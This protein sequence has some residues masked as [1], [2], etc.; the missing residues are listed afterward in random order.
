MY[1]IHETNALSTNDIENFYGEILS[2]T[3]PKH[4]Q[5]FTKHGRRE[6]SV[7]R[8]AKR[9]SINRGECSYIPSATWLT[10]TLH[11][12]QILQAQVQQACSFLRYELVLTDTRDFESRSCTT[13]VHAC[14]SY[15]TLRLLCGAYDSSLY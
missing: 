8:K 7:G 11:L 12:R 1:P 15:S 6:P 14:W 13:G 5:V 4:L 9:K 2:R 10:L 3:I